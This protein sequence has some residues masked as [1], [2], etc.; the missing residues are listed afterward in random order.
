MHDYLQKVEVEHG[1]SWTL[2]SDSS[3]VHS[4]S[5]VIVRSIK[6]KL[7]C[8]SDW[9]LTD[10]RQPGLDLFLYMTLHVAFCFLKFPLSYIDHKV[11][12]YCD[13]CENNH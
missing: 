5:R 1:A 7:H 12:M 6:R 3:G 9:I 2:A 4:I 8:R 11:V 13:S 10:Q